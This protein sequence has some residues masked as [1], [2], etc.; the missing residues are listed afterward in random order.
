MLGEQPLTVRGSQHNLLKDLSNWLLV[1]IYYYP[2]IIT[3][4]GMSIPNFQK[5]SKNFPAPGQAL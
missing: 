2:I 4:T 3:T 5:K 1:L